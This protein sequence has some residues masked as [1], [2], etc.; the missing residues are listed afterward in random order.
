MT[1]LEKAKTLYECQIRMFGNGHFDL[2]VEDAAEVLR[3][4]KTKRKP[5]ALKKCLR[6]FY[7]SHPEKKEIDDSFKESYLQY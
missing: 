3:I 4:L 7:E 2:T 6:D 5:E 1:D